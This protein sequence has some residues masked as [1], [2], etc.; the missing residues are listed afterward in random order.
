[1]MRSGMSSITF[2][3]A[4]RLWLLRTPNTA[5][6]LRIDDDDTPRHVYWGA[7]LAL[8]EITAL[9]AAGNALIS[10]FETL[11]G[12]DE[13]MVAAG[14]RFGPPSLAVR[15]ADGTAAVEWTY[16]GHDV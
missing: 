5:Y 10:S 13:L 12:P 1:M 16:L 2:A 8:P 9:P 3:Q 11:P 15:F 4:E 7:P 6:A 14:A